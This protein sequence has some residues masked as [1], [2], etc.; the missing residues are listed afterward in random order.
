MFKRQLS[1]LFCTLVLCGCVDSTSTDT[2]STVADATSDAVDNSG[3]AAETESQSGDTEVT[4]AAQD[5]GADTTDSTQ[6]TDEED[7]TAD[8][9]GEEPTTAEEFLDAIRGKLADQDLAGAIQL[10][11]TAYA[12]IPDN[13]STLR[14]LAVVLYQSLR[15]EADDATVNKRRLRLGE[16]A[17]ELAERNQESPEN[18][19]DGI[20]GALMLEEAKAHVSAEDVDKAWD[21]VQKARSYGFEQP[22]ML[23]FDP[24]FATLI[25]NKEVMADIKEWLAEEVAAQVEATE[26]FPFDF[27]LTSFDGEEVALADFEGKLLIVDFWGTWCP[28]CRME[29]PHFVELQETRGED[30]AIVG[31][32]IEDPSG[33]AV[34]FESAKASYEKFVATQ[35]INYP[36]LAGDRATVEQVPEF[37]G[38][39]TTLFLDSSGR[40]RLK[41][42]G[43]HPL[44]MLE[45]AVDYLLKDKTTS[46]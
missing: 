20:V 44:P 19:A 7:T 12:T 40:V 35:P 3:Y 45:A 43:Y 4:D 8:S 6:T 27:K 36:C 22:T 18:L 9:D 16:L 41:L 14:T 31:I 26:T 21:L 39:P 24:G 11:E 33:A 38:Y 2:A 17:R 32:N 29:I 30:V 15:G 5:S 46:S 23:F 28:P 25:E 34:D 13:E 1:L 10:A 42:T 37:Q